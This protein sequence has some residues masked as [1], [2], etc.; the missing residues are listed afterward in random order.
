MQN[1]QDIPAPINE[2]N[3]TETMQ[4]LA[5]LFPSDLPPMDPSQ[6]S[7]WTEQERL[8][9]MRGSIQRHLRAG[10]T[11]VEGLLHKGNH[12]KKATSVMSLQH[13]GE[14]GYDPRRDAFALRLGARFI[15]SGPWQ[16]K[17]SF[18]ANVMDHMGRFLDTAACPICKGNRF[19]V[20]VENPN[21]YAKNYEQVFSYCRRCVTP[22]EIRDNEARVM[23]SPSPPSKRQT[24][25]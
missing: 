5:A 7:S 4:R 23:A 8:T 11:W 19:R 16:G 10:W 1:D 25:Y 12:T 15:E 6:S 13:P 9:G 22:E 21:P 14:R 18:G 2:A 20:Q 17:Y 3:A 24:R